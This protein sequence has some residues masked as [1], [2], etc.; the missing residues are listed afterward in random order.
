M[1]RFFSNLLRAILISGYGLASI[2]IPLALA[3]ESE[4]EQLR[5]LNELDDSQLQFDFFSNSSHDEWNESQD[6][7]ELL[8]NNDQEI[9]HDIEDALS[10]SEM[11]DDDYADLEDEELEDE[12]LEDEELEDEELEDEELED[13]ELEDEELEDEDDE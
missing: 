8:E 9:E 11:S 3:D 4:L 7:L 5:K 13:E 12:E 6:A 10:D 2:Y 1:N